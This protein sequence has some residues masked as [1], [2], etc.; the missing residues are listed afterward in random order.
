M[1]VVIANTYWDIFLEG[2]GRGPSDGG[3]L[4][5]SGGCGSGGGQGA[6]GTLLRGLGHAGLLRLGLGLDLGQSQAARCG[7]GAL[8]LHR[9]VP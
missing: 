5:S 1:L 4:G 2:A 3:G 7:D 6:G 8:H 9:R